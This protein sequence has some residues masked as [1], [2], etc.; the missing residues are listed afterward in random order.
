MLQTKGGLN[1]VPNYEDVIYILHR[2]AGGRPTEPLLYQIAEE[3]W[4]RFRS[5]TAIEEGLLDG[6]LL[7]AIDCMTC[8]LSE[9]LAPSNIKQTHHLA[10]LP[11]IVNEFQPSNV[12]IATTNHDML[13][14]HYLRGARINWN[15]GFPREGEDA[16]L[17]RPE[18]LERGLDAVSLLKIHGSINWYQMMPTKDCNFGGEYARVGPDGKLP[19]RHADRILRPSDWHP[20]MVIGTLNKVE[21]YLSG[22]IG[23][24]ISLFRRALRSTRN[25][26]IVG[27]GFRDVGVNTIL[28]EWAFESRSRRFIVVDP[29]PHVVKDTDWGNWWKQLINADVAHLIPKSLGGDVPL[30]WEDLKG[31]LI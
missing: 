11:D 9:L 6:R 16:N 29:N 1:R 4:R 13:I 10:F 25:L 14:E 24:S 21:E 19:R 7:N 22:I 3:L 15:D 2:I 5:F 30:V 31:F 26:V 28:F 27:Y 8:L 17:W 23:D 12:T 18:I 20:R